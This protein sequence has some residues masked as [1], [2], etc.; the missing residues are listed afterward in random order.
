M[1]I[2][3][4]KGIKLSGG[5]TRW[6]PGKLAEYDRAHGLDLPPPEGM[7]DVRQVARRYGVSVPTVW[8]WAS[9]GGEG[10]GRDAA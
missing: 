4:P 9:K 6:S 2:P 5:A 3:F 1:K 8:R 10:Q 7:L